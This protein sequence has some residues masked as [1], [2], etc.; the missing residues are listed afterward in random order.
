MVLCF[1][2]L[3]PSQ[4]NGFKIRLH[5]LLPDLGQVFFNFF[6]L[7]SASVNEDNVSSYFLKLLRLLWGVDKIMYSEY[8]SQEHPA[9]LI[10]YQNRIIFLF[11][12]IFI[13]LF[14]RERT[15]PGRGEEEQE[16][17][18]DKADLDMGLNLT[19]LGSQPEPK[20]RVRCT[21]DWATGY[22]RIILNGI[23]G[24]LAFLH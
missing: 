18:R 2:G 24:Q 1:R 14:E 6:A 19:T 5:H 17:D 10:Y 11:F 16:R 20:P 15:H 4:A 9:H 12:K 13:H 3:A 7:I 8:C 22:N 21:T 23:S